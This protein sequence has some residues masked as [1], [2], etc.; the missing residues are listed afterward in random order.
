MSLLL[1]IINLLLHASFIW[2]RFAVFRVGDRLPEGAK[3]IQITSVPCIVLDALLIAGRTG[4]HSILDPLAIALALL[5][6][7]L[8]AWAVLTTGLRRLTAVFSEDLPAELIVS[9]P[10]RFVRNPFYLAYVLAYLQALV[11]ARSWWAAC[12]LVVMA[13]LYY[14]AALFEERKFLRGDLALQYR[15]YAATTGRFLPMFIPRARTTSN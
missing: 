1:L 9:G 14:R 6:G 8:F 4:D 5:S 10:F 13:F 3:L 11:A 15:R 12:P 7:V 2:G